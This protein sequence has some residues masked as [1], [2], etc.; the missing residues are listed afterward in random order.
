MNKLAVF[1]LSFT[2][3]GLLMPRYVV[4][5]DNQQLMYKEFISNAAVAGTIVSS[6][7]SGGYINREDTLAPTAHDNVPNGYQGPFNPLPRMDNGYIFYHIEVAYRSE[8]GRAN[9]IDSVNKEFNINNYDHIEDIDNISLHYSFAGKITINRYLDV[10]HED[11]LLKSEDLYGRVDV[12]YLQTIY[13]A[14]SINVDTELNGY[15][16]INSDIDIN[17]PISF[18][19]ADQTVNLVYEKNKQI[20]SIHV[21]HIDETGDI[22]V[23]TDTF[24][25]KVGNP[26]TVSSAPINGYHLLSSTDNTT[27]I[28]TEDPINIIYTYRKDVLNGD[29]IVSYLDEEGNSLLDDELLTGTVGTPYSTA[30]KVINGYELISSPISAKGTFTNDSIKVI[31]KYKKK[32]QNGIINVHYR[33]EKGLKIAESLIKEG[34]VGSSYNSTSI[35]IDGYN[36]ISQTN[37]TQ[38]IYTEEPIEIIYT[39]QKNDTD[40]YVHISYLDINGDKILQDTVL[41][42]IIG[43]SFS[44]EAIKIE[45]Y[46]LVNLPTSESGIFSEQRINIIYTYKEIE[47]NDSD[48][49][50]DDPEDNKNF[51]DQ[52]V[53]PPTGYNSYIS[54]GFINISL[55]LILR[56]INKKPQENK[57]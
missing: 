5:A 3:I 8:S 57:I 25:G 52:E 22:I 56:K 32:N 33:D 24:T 50:T 46:E 6:Q 27:G 42:G 31:Y 7:F 23:P 16:L 17:S 37:N 48:T 18:Q 26:Y 40:G 49:S 41:T 14:E 15:T 1:I 38:G 44:T 19:D 36:L 51:P 11:N 39:Y 4:D 2:L 12:S 9:Y 54:L 55:G 47:L 35:D 29:V 13:S 43:T 10:V 20:G 28:F 30:A 53:L 34:A 45:G 21:S